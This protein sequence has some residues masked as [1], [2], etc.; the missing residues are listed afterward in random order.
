LITK[1][2]K[3]LNFSKDYSKKEL[4]SS[5]IYAIINRLNNKFYI[6]SAKNFSLR[7]STHLNDLKNNDHHSIYLQRSIFKNGIDNFEFRIIEFVEE[8]YLIEIEQ[9][10]L[11]S[12]NCGYNLSK[13]AG[14]TL[15]YK[16][17]Q[18][19]KES[20]SKNSTKALEFTLFSPLGEKF[21]GKNREKFCISKGL[22]TGYISAVLKGKRFQHKGWTS[23]LE[24]HIDYKNRY[25]TS[26]KQTVLHKFINPQGQ[27]IETYSLHALVTNFGLDDKGIHK[28]SRGEYKS[29]R[30]W[31]LA[32]D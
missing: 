21:E 20:M 27:V 15:G 25:R 6:G 16:H 31:K 9:T 26:F 4:N 29:H 19:T 30:G 23:S 5:G 11:D 22:N 1:L 10:Y 28:L 14:S 12:T 13:I 8:E 18:K 2:R 24:N 3:S 17:S 32:K 7:L